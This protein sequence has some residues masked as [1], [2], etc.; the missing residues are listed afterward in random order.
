MTGS[1]LKKDPSER[2]TAA[3]LLQNPF[4]KKARDKT[5][6]QHTFRGISQSF[7]T[8]LRDVTIERNNRVGKTYRVEWI[9]PPSEAEDDEPMELLDLD[10]DAASPSRAQIP[11]VARLDGSLY[12]D[13]KNRRVT[14][15]YLKSVVLDYFV[16]REN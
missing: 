13:V 7:L 9:F 11:T 15:Q 3:E 16:S 1:C 14:A 8:E 5:Y 2:L 4:F 12:T 10:M 6:L